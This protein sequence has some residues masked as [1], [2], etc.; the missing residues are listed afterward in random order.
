MGFSEVRDRELIA[1]QNQA[2]HLAE[3]AYN[4]RLLYRQT[5]DPGS[6]TPTRAEMEDAGRKMQ[7]AFL[8][9]IRV[10]GEYI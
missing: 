6:P 4:L 5:D 9:V 1:I 10:T 7:G 8:A 3:C 2:R